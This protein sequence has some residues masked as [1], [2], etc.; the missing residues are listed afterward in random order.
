M[1]CFFLSVKLFTGYEAFSRPMKLMTGNLHLLLTL[2][3]SDQPRIKLSILL[4]DEIKNGE[5]IKVRM[6][7][8][9]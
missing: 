7:L 3:V 8:V 9:I 2:I 1:L 6:G 4:A 5:V